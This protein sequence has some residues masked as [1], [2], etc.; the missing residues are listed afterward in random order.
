MGASTIE[1]ASTE[2][3]I[4][5]RSMKVNTRIEERSIADFV[6][7]D[8]AGSASYARGQPIAIYDPDDT[9]I[10]GGFINT[11]ERK[12]ISPSGGLYHPITCMDNHYL[13][14]KRLVVESYSSELAGDIVKDIRT[15]YLAAEG[16]TIGEIQDGIE[17]SEAIF[18]YIKGSE[19]YDALAEL[20]GFTWF[21]NELKKLY[22]IDRSTNA[23]P[24]AFTRSD[25]IRGS[26]LIEGNPLYRNRQYIR[27]GTGVTSLQVE[28]RTGDGS[29]EAFAMG[30]PLAEEPTITENEV[31]KTVGIKGL[32]TGKHWYWSKGDNT[33]Y[34][35]DAPGDGVA[36]Q[37][38]Y[39]GQYPLI[40]RADDWGGVADRKAIEGGTG[41]IED[42]VHEAQHESGAASTESAA[43]KLAEYCRNAE[44]FIFQT[45][46]SGL[47][48]G[49]LLPVTYLPFGFSSHDMLIESVVIRADGDLLTYDVSAITGPAMGS[50][51][52]FFSSILERQD[53]SIRIGDSLL[54]VLLQARE[55]LTLAEATNRHEDLSPC[56]GRWLALP[57]TQ[58]AGHHVVHEKLAL[59]E[60]VDRTENL[61][62]E[63][64]WQ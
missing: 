26:K 16:I 25:A 58:G 30:F 61:K 46:R 48:P 34:A 14:D 43:A 32:E 15:K 31:E 55:T 12:P 52:K 19:A 53:K 42:I 20:T 8:L 22:F 5:R 28:D 38:S 64:A 17:I 57:P 33:I 6:V 37:C 44:K 51:S 62:G 18:N 54:L 3:V 1:I 59:E 10:F 45:H 27:G 60:A 7:V 35:E 47:K 49:Q 11:A 39:K 56:T 23:S 13:A 2:V 41:I 9:L 29:T 36:I 24:W 63:Y 40:S 50:W 4:A 21:I